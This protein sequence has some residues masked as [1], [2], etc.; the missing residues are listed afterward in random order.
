[1]SELSAGE[2]LSGKPSESRAK[3]TLVSK[4][5]LLIK[6]MRPKQWTKNLIVY[7][8]LFFA[9]KMQDASLFIDAS[10]CVLAFCLVSSAIY[11]FNDIL[12]RSADRL[13]PKKC[14]R[15]L[16]SGELSVFEA[17]SL[18][19]FLLPAGLALSFAVRPSLMLVLLFYTVMT[20]AYSIKLK[21]LPIVDVCVISAGFVLRAVAGAVAV[22]VPASAWFLLCTTLGALF[23]GLE[24]RRNELATLKDVAESHRRSLDN[25]SFGLINR[26]EAIV[27]PSL[28][29]CYIFYSFLSEHGQWM[30]LTVPFVL[31][32]I[33][34]YVQLSADESINLTGSP[35]EVLLKDRPIQAT[36]ILWAITS[37]A[38]LEEIPQRWLGMIAHNFDLLAK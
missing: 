10:A 31:Y 18:A 13:H 29:T 3:Q 27:L 1:M 21:H 12:D 8:P 4:C 37:A 6:L 19:L 9:H 16:A 34:R 25:Y 7:I 33:M 15:P 11:I 38:V 23:L 20:V 22:N 26:I 35:E 36:V 5:L 30:M 2:D 32:G 14:K 24:K 28:L 17:V